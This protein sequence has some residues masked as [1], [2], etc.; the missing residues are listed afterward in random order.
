MN[1]SI[2]QR[3]KGTWQLRYDAPP[4]GTGKRQFVRGN[5]QGGFMSVEEFVAEMKTQE[6]FQRAFDSEKPPGSGTPPGG[7]KKPVLV[8]S[9]EGDKSP[10]EK[11]AAGLAAREGK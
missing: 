9:K 5:K 3:S 1:G 2:R 11:I 6:Q 8:K 4:D 10:M 7:P